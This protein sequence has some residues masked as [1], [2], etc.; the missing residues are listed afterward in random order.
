MKNIEDFMDCMQELNPE[1]EN[2]V[3]AIEWAMT[4]VPLIDE[5]IWFGNIA[6][7]GVYYANSRESRWFPG[8]TPEMAATYLAAEML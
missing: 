4:Q 5:N 6:N 8:Y 7:K 1:I 3:E 2:E